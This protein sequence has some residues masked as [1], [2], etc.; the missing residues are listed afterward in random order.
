MVFTPFEPAIAKALPNLFS[1]KYKKVDKM[2]R[3]CF[4]FCSSLHFIT[5]LLRININ[6]WFMFPFK[7]CDY[8]SVVRIQFLVTFL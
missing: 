8:T 1:T 2:R 4:Q 6:K 3:C 5:I 7:L